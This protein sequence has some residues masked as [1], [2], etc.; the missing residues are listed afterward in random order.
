MGIFSKTDKHSPPVFSNPIV[1]YHITR[2]LDG[3]LA[4]SPS[5]PTYNTYNVLL[6]KPKTF[7]ETIEITLVHANGGAVG[8]C[9]TQVF[10]GKAVD[11]SVGGNRG[12]EFRHSGHGSSAKY[13]LRAGDRTVKDVEWAHD[14]LAGGTAPHGRLKLEDR[15][16]N[17]LARF[18]GAGGRVGELGMLEIYHQGQAVADAGVDWCGLIIFT[19][20]CAYLRE[21]R[22]AEAKKRASYLNAFGAACSMIG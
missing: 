7:R 6:D 14:P 22:L 18:A 4:V 3:R 1:T 10:T 5:S 15:E 21:E 11:F 13:A 17:V 9:V 19:A 2:L 8:H 12:L 20:L 16:G